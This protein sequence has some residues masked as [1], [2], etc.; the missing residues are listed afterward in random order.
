MFLHFSF[1]LMVPS[2][3]NVLS[4]HPP[5]HTLLNE[6]NSSPLLSAQYVPGALLSPLQA[7]QYFIHLH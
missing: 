1:V 2:A 7:L 4:E 3:W 6:D 5:T